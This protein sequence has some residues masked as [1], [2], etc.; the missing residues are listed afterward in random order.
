M[1]AGT[2]P[3][4]ILAESC[5]CGP[6]IRRERRRGSPRRSARGWRTPASR[7]RC[8]RWRP[9][10]ATSSRPFATATAPLSS[11]TPIW[12]R[13]RPARPGR[14]TRS[15]RRSSRG[16]S[17]DEAP[18]TRK[19]RS[20]PCWQRPLHWA[21]TGRAGA[22]R[23][24]S[25]SS[26]TRRPRASGPSTMPGTVRRPTSPSSASRPET[27][28]SPPIAAACAC[29]FGWRAARPIPPRRTRT[30]TPSSPPPPF[31]AGSRR[32]ARA[33]RASGIPSAAPRP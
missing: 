11:S 10:A 25:S 4:D 31:S 12:T 22:E 28:S 21:T 2:S 30:S 13:C 14:A 23:S 20:P 1:I 7:S 16:G 29:W 15:A 9:G 26:W 8:R 24:S 5:P 33:S 32:R 17:T 18:A 6:S 19:A 27:A 3:T